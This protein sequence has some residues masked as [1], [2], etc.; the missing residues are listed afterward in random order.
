MTVSDV[1]LNVVE[2]EGGQ[3]CVST[4]LEVLSWTTEEEKYDVEKIGNGTLAVAY[5]V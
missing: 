3:M 4:D 5:E 2:P 1:K